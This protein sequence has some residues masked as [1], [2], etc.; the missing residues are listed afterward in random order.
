MRK[1]EV[2][3]SEGQTTPRKSRTPL[4]KVLFFEV[5][6]P[7]KSSKSNYSKKSCTLFEKRKM[8]KKKDEKAKDRLVSKDEDF[9][10]VV[11]TTPKQHLAS[12]QI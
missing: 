4:A 9:P 12:W 10:Y 5:Q 1:I 11:G 7:K 2:D 8:Y 6:I 3:Y